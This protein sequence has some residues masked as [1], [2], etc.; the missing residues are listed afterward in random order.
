MDIFVQD[1]KERMDAGNTP[2]MIDVRNP[3][4]W[5]TQHLEGV[6]LISLNDIPT[7]LEELAPIKDEEIVLICRSGARSGQ[8]TQFLRTNGFNNVR[9]LVGGMMAWKAYIDPTFNV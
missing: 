3:H 5:E 2:I 6:R 4:E 1:L 8:A 7:S 9:N